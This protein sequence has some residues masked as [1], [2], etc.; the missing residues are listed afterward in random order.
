MAMLI[1]DQTVSISEDEVQITAIRAQGAGGQHVN[2][3]ASAVHLRFDV[4]ASSLPEHYRQRL[5]ATTDQRLNKA[6]EIVI[7]AQSHRDFERNRADALQRLAAMIRA[8]TAVSARRR[9]TR[10]S[11]SARQRRVD[12]KAHRGQQKQLRRKI[13]D[14]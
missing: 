14:D 11:R 8:A 9:P 10:P 2:K 3:T 5:L 7:K 6:G 1:I 13:R 12:D 4:A